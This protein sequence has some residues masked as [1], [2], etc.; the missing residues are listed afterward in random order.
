[1]LEIIIVAVIFGSIWV[2]A[3]MV[4]WRAGTKWRVIGA[5]ILGAVL[6]LGVAKG[7]YELISSR[8]FQLFGEMVT[9]IE[10][11]EKVVA[12]TFDDGPT[13]AFTEPVLDILR[14]K[15]V[16]ATFFLTGSESERNIEALRAIVA[17]GHEIGNHSWSHERMIFKSR[18]FIESELE[19]TDAAIRAGG[20]E[21]PIHFRSPYGKRFVTLPWV[22]RETG[23]K[24]IF[25]DI[26]PESYRDVAASSDRIVAH[27][28]ERARP[29]SIVLL[30]VM[31]PARETTREALPVLID[32]LRK[33]GFRFVTPGELN[34]ER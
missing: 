19:R 34:D 12:L 14:E 9:R 3:A 11:S 7:L 31:Y 18:S 25:W 13:I 6:T 24:N 4:A 1:M 10:T 21:G 28:V 20:Y 2:G 17:D 26:E 27:V 30:H 32:E 8:S 5:V 33:R 15:D 29:G 22:L 23:R 16:R